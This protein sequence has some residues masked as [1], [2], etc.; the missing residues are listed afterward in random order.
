[1]RR[2]KERFRGICSSFGSFFRRNLQIKRMPLGA[3]AK[4]KKWYEVELSDR[5]PGESA[6][7]VSGSFG[8]IQ[9]ER[10]FPHVAFRNRENQNERRHD[11]S[12]RYFSRG[13]R[14]LHTR[15]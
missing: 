8:P 1:M 15:N 3:R 2:G 10:I 14:Y 4:K 12:G 9:I 11:S 13:P 5:K 7:H 6:C